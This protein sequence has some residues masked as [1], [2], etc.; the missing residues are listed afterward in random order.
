MSPPRAS[1]VL[2]EARIARGLTQRQLADRI[3]GSQ[4]AIAMF[5]GGRVDA[6]SAD[7][8]LAVAREL[9]IPPDG[10]LSAKTHSVRMQERPTLVYCSNPECCYVRTS[11]VNRA[12]GFVPRFLEAKD[13]PGPHCCGCGEL[14]RSTCPGCDAPVTPGIRCSNCG[15]PLVITG[16]YGGDYQEDPDPFVAWHNA[17]KEQQRRWMHEGATV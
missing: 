4:S 9:R 7:K 13:A 17:E 15:D 3:D 5:E 10:L 11:R 8:L 12:V 14:L 16:P 2:R 1:R 6:L